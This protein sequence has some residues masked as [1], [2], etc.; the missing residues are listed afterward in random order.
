M[1]LILVYWFVLGKIFA[2]QDVCLSKQDNEI[3]CALLESERYL[4]HPWQC[5]YRFNR[6]APWIRY[7]E[8][9]NCQ[10]LY[11][12]LVPFSLIDSSP[13]LWDELFS[14]TYAPTWIDKWCL[15]NVSPITSKM[16]NSSRYP[17]SSWGQEFH[18]DPDND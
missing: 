14:D 1:K 12:D 16:P 3:F 7:F 13:T 10:V 2:D 6:D 8:T 17:E 11:Q 15:G 4:R 9:H 18:H 5:F